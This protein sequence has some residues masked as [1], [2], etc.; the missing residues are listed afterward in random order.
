MKKIDEL[1]M[2]LESMIEQELSYDI[3][4]KKSQE[5]DKLITKETK[6]IN[7]E[8]IARINKVKT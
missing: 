2:E 5:I 4:L 1:K 6:I 3:I 8:N 7:K